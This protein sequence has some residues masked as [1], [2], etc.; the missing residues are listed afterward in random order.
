MQG[1]QENLDQLAKLIRESLE[2]FKQTYEEIHFG[3]KYPVPYYTVLPYSQTSSNFVGGKNPKT[4][5]YTSL[6]EVDPDVSPK[7]EF[8]V[9]IDLDQFP[10][11]TR[12][13]AYLDSNLSVAINNGSVKI[14][15]VAYKVEKENADDSK[16][17]DKCDAFVK[18]SVDAMP[19][20][21]ALVTLSLKRKR[22]EWVGKIN[23]DTL[24]VKETLRTKTFGWANIIT[25]FDQAYENTATDTYF[26]QLNISLIKK[27]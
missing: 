3:D 12:T 6:Q 7:T 19:G 21:I 14:L 16:L 15:Q 20:N 17:T 1:K 25:G 27:Q 2:T 11:F 5:S 9:G 13:T 8:W 18:L 24:A 23:H 4:G 26:N 10:T 22:P